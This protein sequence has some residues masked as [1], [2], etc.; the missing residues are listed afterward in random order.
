M[1]VHTEPPVSMDIGEVTV[2]LYIIYLGL[3]ANKLALTIYAV[4]MCTCLA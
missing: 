3:S 1:Y 2:N 4:C